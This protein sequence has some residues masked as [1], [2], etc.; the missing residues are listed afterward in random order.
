MNLAYIIVKNKIS[1]YRY[2]IGRISLL[3]YLLIF[4]FNLFHFHKFDFNEISAVDIKNEFSL[5]THLS[6]SE[7]ICIIHQNFSSLQYAIVNF[8]SIPFLLNPNPIFFTSCQDKNKFCSL[9]LSDNFLRAPPIL[10]Y[11]V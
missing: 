3:C 9:H 7:F 10:S 6:N 11:F 8:S 5:Q 2:L 1:K 4:F